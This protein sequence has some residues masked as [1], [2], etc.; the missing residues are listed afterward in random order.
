MTRRR[1]VVAG[2]I[3]AVVAAMLAWAAVRMSHH[4]A[5]LQ[6][7][8]ATPP[9]SS[10]SGFQAVMLFFPAPSGESLVGE[11]RSVIAQNDLHA[12]VGTLI[13]EL[14]RGPL[15]GGMTLLPPGTALQHAYLDDRGL[16][17]LDLSPAFRDVFHGGG[18]AELLVVGSLVRTLAVNV[19]EAHRLQLACGGQP[20]PSLGGHV[21]LDQ[22]LDLSHWPAP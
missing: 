16:L 19:P 3:V 8:R 4:V 12:R 5:G 1:A 11:S 15:A 18:T 10:A 13:G 7:G 6:R 9:D 2:A 17:T 21:P 20:L 22:P 14:G